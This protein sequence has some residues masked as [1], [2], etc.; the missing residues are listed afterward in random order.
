MLE[1]SWLFSP[2]TLR[3]LSRLDVLHSFPDVVSVFFL[4]GF[5]SASSGSTT[6]LFFLV[7]SLG[8]GPGKVCWQLFWTTLEG[9][10]YSPASPSNG[11]FIS[12][13]IFHVSLVRL[14]WFSELLCLFLSSSMDDLTLAVPIQEVKSCNIAL[15]ERIF[16]LHQDLVVGRGLPLHIIR[17]N[18]CCSVT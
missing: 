13:P 16:A 14:S 8:A 18:G 6:S 1:G 15:M 12:E 7:P 17:S 10:E 9:L 2:A 11:G 3:S 4:L 5:V